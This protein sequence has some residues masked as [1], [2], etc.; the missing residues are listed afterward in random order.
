MKSYFHADVLFMSVH[1]MYL[2]MMLTAPCR[3]MC[4]YCKA[5]PEGLCEYGPWCFALSRRTLQSGSPCSSCASPRQENGEVAERDAHEH[6]DRLFCILQGK[7]EDMLRSIEES[8][9]RRLGSLRGQVDE[10]QGMLENSGLVGYA[11]EVLKE[12]D[13]SCFVQTAKQLH[14]RSGS[15]LPPCLPLPKLVTLDFWGSVCVLSSFD[16]LSFKGFTC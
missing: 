11:Q 1:A 4:P 13:Q 2:N 12:T 7:K 8:K 14:I 5:W 9:T 6:F 15:A 10:Y 3:F 16:I